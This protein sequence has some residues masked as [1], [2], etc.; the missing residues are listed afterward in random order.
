M[1]VV[2]IKTGE[3][4]DVADG[5]ARNYLL[6]RKIAVQATP[7]MVEKAK[8]QQASAQKSVQEEANQWE[9]LMKKL[10]EVTVHLQA[11]ANENGSLF[12]AVH[13][14]AIVQAMKDEYTILLESGWLQIE[15]PI[16]H[17]GSYT[18]QVQFPNKQRT[19]FQLQV[20]A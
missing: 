1:K 20:N 15:E 2:M 8:K 19:S 6:P 17:T 18:I 13:E 16:K 14:A 9:E 5:Y 3:I 10:P 4:K 11:K 7:E 12:A